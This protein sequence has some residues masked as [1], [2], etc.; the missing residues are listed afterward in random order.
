MFSIHSLHYLTHAQ[1]DWT[2][3]GDR[4]MNDPFTCKGFV[5]VPQSK[6]ENL[7]IVLKS[8]LTFELEYVNIMFYTS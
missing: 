6:L 2:L 3:N 7:C 5:D 4:P 8:C 1:T